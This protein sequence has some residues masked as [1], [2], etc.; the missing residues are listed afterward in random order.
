[1]LLVDFFSFFV[2]LSFFSMFFFCLLLYQTIFRWLPSFLE[3]FFFDFKES[4]QKALKKILD[5]IIVF[6]KTAAVNI[7]RISNPKS[8]Q[9]NLVKFRSKL[10]VGYFL[11]K[12]LK[13][14]VLNF[15]NIDCE[16]MVNYKNDQ[17]LRWH[18]LDLFERT[19]KSYFTHYSCVVIALFSTGLCGSAISTISFRK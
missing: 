2:F 11:G 6:N 18:L 16:F 15:F 9:W 5:Q 4:T 12:Y 19:T 17:F 7:S 10:E 3:F 1:M 8:P 14:S 13:N